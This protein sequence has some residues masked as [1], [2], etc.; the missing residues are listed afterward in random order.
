MYNSLMT[1]HSLTTLSSTTATMLT[2]LGL[3]TGMDIT[4]QNVHA[5]AIVYL[6]ASGVTAEDY[7]YRLLPGLA[8]SFE[9][10]GRNALFAITDTN[11]SQIAILK[12]GLEIGH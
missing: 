9:L 8:I 6:G 4:I 11:E 2:P 12:T 7:G 3:H 10:P 1:T 5:T